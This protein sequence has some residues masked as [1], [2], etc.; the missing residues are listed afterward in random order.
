MQL[1]ECERHQDILALFPRLVTVLAALHSCH[2]A[3][4]SS[5]NWTSLD[6]DARREAEIVLEL[7]EKLTCPNT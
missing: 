3:F 2:R 7:A 5:E 1:A 6:D 4:S